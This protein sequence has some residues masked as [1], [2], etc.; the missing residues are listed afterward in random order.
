M[1]K[2][3]DFN[4]A[5]R[6]VFIKEEFIRLI[7]EILIDPTEIKKTIPEDKF[8]IVSDCVQSL[9]VA[10]CTCG[11]CINMDKLEAR[12]PSEL[13]CLIE[14]SRKRCEEKTYL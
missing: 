14:M 6:I 5:E 2:F 3:T 7:E 1:A 8:K 4:E 10:E 11:Q 9:K 12:V 13:Q